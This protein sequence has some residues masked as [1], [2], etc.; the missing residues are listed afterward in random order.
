[1]SSTD[2]NALKTLFQN[3]ER[4]GGKSLLDV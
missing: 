2:K 3:V 1:M 4:L